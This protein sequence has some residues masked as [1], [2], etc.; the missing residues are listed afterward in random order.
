VKRFVAAAVIVVGV[1]ASFIIWYRLSDGRDNFTSD[2]VVRIYHENRKCTGS[3]LEGGRVILTAAHCA[4][5][6]KVFV[7]G[8][9]KDQKIASCWTHPEYKGRVPYFDVAVCRLDGSVTETAGA[10]LES[11]LDPVG[12]SVTYIGFARRG[13][14]LELFGRLPFAG[15][16]AG[17]VR[18]VAAGT[19]ILQGDPVYDGDSGGPVLLGDPDRRSIVG[20]ISCYQGKDRQPRAVNLLDEMN[21]EWVSACVEDE[22]ACDRSPPSTPVRQLPLCD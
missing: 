9:G 5:R 13:A 20:V 21:R 18:E 19:L 1:V 22:R 8:R 7:K 2:F 15:R 16:A 4:T 12:R 10:S 17:I 6:G 14:V 3:I 11:P